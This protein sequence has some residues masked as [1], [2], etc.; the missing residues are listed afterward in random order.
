M[1]FCASGKDTIELLWWQT[2]DLSCIHC[3][4]PVTLSLRLAVALDQRVLQEL[5]LTDGGVHR[6]STLEEA[7][8]FCERLARSHYENFPVGSFIVDASRRPAF[9]AIYCFSRLADDVADHLEVESKQRLSILNSFR[10]QLYAEVPSQHPIFFALHHTRQT[11]QL[12]VE[13]FE[14]LLHAFEMDSV[15]EQAAT[16]QDLLSYCSYSANPVGELLLRLYGECDAANL[17]H[18]NEICTAL[19]LINFWQDFSRD[20]AQGRFYVPL[21]LCQLYQTSPQSLAEEQ[22]SAKFPSLHQELLKD[23]IRRSDELMNAGARLPA[24]ISNRRLR[25]ELCFIIEGGRAILNAIRELDTEIFRTRPSLRW[26][27]RFAMIWRSVK[28]YRSLN[29]D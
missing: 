17:Q 24:L 2:I 15:F 22:F 10:E 21:E 16:W 12:P 7:Y 14:R 4:F 25:L 19:Q 27:D 9:Y 13:A 6:C 23:L 8:S 1:Q 28:R 29:N 5:V 11:F 18:S 20:L 26:S 3:P